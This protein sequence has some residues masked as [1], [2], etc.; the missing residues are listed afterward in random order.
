MVLPFPG[1]PHAYVRM[2]A[3]RRWWDMETRGLGGILGPG[4]RESA[5]LL[6]LEVHRG[7]RQGAIGGEDV[8]F[9]QR[10]APEQAMKVWVLRLFSQG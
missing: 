2:V 4:L 9:L 5:M 10:F 6:L 1:W 7:A 3:V 8:V